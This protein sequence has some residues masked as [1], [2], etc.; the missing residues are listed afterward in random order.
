MIKSRDSFA[1]SAPV[2]S[3]NKARISAIFPAILEVKS[4]FQPL[5]L[6]PL[7]GMKMLVICPR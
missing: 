1:P 5:A 2:L 3:S 7:N 6:I 4:T